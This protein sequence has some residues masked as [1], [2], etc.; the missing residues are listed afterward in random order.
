[1]CGRE[2]ADWYVLDL[3]ATI[4]PCTSRKEDA[5]GTFKGSF[6]HMPLSAWVGRH[7]RV[8]R[9]AAAAGHR[10]APPTDVTDHKAILAS[11]FRQLPLPLWSKLL[12]R[13]G[14]RGLQP[15]PARSSPTAVHAPAPVRWVTGWAVNATDE[16]AIALLPE[17]VWT[18]ALRQDARGA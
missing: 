9:H 7:P 18:A 17:K 1:V 11:A 13:I 2:P 16:Q 8:R 5:A 4:V 10:P 6:G 3:D 15:R 14:R 12:V